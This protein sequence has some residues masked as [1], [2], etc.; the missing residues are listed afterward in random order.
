MIVELE[1]D[2][3][4]IEVD[5]SQLERLLA[6]IRKSRPDPVEEVRDCLK[7]VAASIALLPRSVEKGVGAVRIP[8]PSSPEPIPA[9]QRIIVDNIRRNENNLIAYLELRLVRERSVD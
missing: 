4:I 3:E 1:V 7:S 9:V 5:E 2:G 6:K 8:V